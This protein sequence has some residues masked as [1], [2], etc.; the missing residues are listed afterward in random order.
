M[1]DYRGPGLPLLM[2]AC[3][4][5]LIGG[6]FAI[7]WWKQ[8]PPGT[9]RERVG[10]PPPPPVAAAPGGIRSNSPRLLMPVRPARDDRVDELRRELARTRAQLVQLEEFRTRYR[11]RFPDEADLDWSNAIAAVSREARAL[12]EAGEAGDD[13]E[14]PAEAPDGNAPTPAAPGAADPPPAGSD[15]AARIRDLERRLE[16]AQ[17]LDEQ[18]RVEVEQLRADLAEMTEA[19]AVETERGREVAR[20]LETERHLLTDA[21]RTLIRLGAAAVPQLV[22]ALLAQDAETREWAAD[23]LGALGDAARPALPDLR[24]ARSDPDPG[25]RTAIA[26]AIDAIEQADVP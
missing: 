18:Q 13:A 14:R 2:A 4:A 25:V 20:L 10:S 1:N 21:S 3:I 22:E 26:R 9:F 17:F 16:I 8:P 24:D 7:T 15:L 19:L 11:E 6:V 5:L 23:V 12:L